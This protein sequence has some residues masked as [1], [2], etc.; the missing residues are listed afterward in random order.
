[1]IKLI[2]VQKYSYYRSRTGPFILFFYKKEDSEVIDI[3][4]LYLIKYLQTIERDFSDLPLLGFD[5]KLFKI[6]YNHEK[7]TSCNDI[8]VIRKDHDFECYNE[9]SYEKINQ[10][11]N[12]IRK[13]RINILM[14]N[15]K[16]FH[17]YKKTN[18]RFKWSGF[19]NSNKYGSVCK[20]YEDRIRQQNE[21]MGIKVDIQIPEYLPKESKTKIQKKIQT[22]FSHFKIVKENKKSRKSKKKLETNHAKFTKNFQNVNFDKQIDVSSLRHSDYP[23]YH[24]YYSHF[25]IPTASIGY[26]NSE[27]HEKNRYIFNQLQSTDLTKRGS[28]L[29]SYN[30]SDYFLYYSK[31]QTHQSPKISDDQITQKYKVQCD[32]KQNYNLNYH[33]E[34]YS[35]INYKLYKKVNLQKNCDLQPENNGYIHNHH[36]NS[37]LQNIFDKSP[38]MQN[39][40]NELNVESNKIEC[41]SNIPKCTE[42]SFSN[43]E[44]KSIFQQSHSPTLP[45]FSSFLNKSKAVPISTELPHISNI[46]MCYN[47]MSDFSKSFTLPISDKNKNKDSMLE[48]TIDRFMS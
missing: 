46:N 25:Y 13:E 33:K 19:F 24:K 9:P 6:C 31:L 47:E 20:R 26:Q 39:Q 45:P 23:Y 16:I 15:N 34:V 21:I 1:M 48:K 44:N 17:Q 37:F 29:P 4:N 11:F 2:D 40:Y 41:H 10:I 5:F 22:N 27:C 38:E 30:E 8:C 35:Q 18:P 14:K 3:K 42:Y 7:I 28:Y 43:N 36:Q 12:S 32:Y